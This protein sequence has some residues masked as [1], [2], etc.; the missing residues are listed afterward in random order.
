MMERRNWQNETEAD[1][2]LKEKDRVK[3]RVSYPQPQP[4]RRE[5]DER[6]MR[7]IRQAIRSDRR[8]LGLVESDC[9]WFAEPI[10]HM[11]DFLE[12]SVEEIDPLTLRDCL[13]LIVAITDI[14]AVRDSIIC[15]CIKSLDIRQGQVIACKP[16]T[17][18]STQLVCACLNPAFN[19]IRAPR[20][21]KQGQRLFVLLRAWE[22]C[23]G[24]AYRAQLNA[25]LAYI[26]WWLGYPHLSVSYAKISLGL[27]EDCA[28]ASIVKQAVEWQAMPAW[29][30][31]R[32]RRQRE[33]ICRTSSE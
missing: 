1:M 21:T 25:T 19:D 30:R 11:H 18:E 14:R 13:I 9:R 17:K 27:D 3:E 28:L 26:A 32:E 23:V 29:Y 2:R 15:M 31:E 5:E 22:N 20:R 10:A 16:Q 33:S 24:E 4:A 6:Q 7:A 12:S 8:E